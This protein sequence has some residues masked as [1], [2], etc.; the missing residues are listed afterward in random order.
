MPF[1]PFPKRFLNK[2]ANSAVLI[3]EGQQVATGLVIG[4]TR[5]VPANDSDLE[6]AVR[7][8]ARLV[9]RV[10]YSVLRN[11][12]DAE[13]ATQETFVR[14][15][16]YRRKLVGVRNPRTWLARIGLRVALERR[17]KASKVSFK[18]LDAAAPQICSRALPADEAV[19]ELE[20]GGHVEKLIAALP[21][22]L[23]DPLTLSAVEEM[24]PADVAE[25]LGI[26]EAAVRSRV[27]RARQI[28]REKL[29]SVLEG[30]YGI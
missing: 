22:K 29:S 28:L 13:D 6:F 24:S 5:D 17:N 27:F 30:K 10:A 9:Y 8:H 20:M 2:S 26:N 14:V 7:Q 25:V 19:L 11:H 15:L 1:L 21:G 12:H 4:E 23:R 3:C 18:D 16:R